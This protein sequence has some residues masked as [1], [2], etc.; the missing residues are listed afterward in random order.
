MNLNVTVNEGC[1]SAPSTPGTYN[2]RAHYNETDA[3]QL[4]G[5]FGSRERA[6]ECLLVVAARPDVIKAEIETV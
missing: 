6:E 5:P 1:P 3:G 4:F 2:V